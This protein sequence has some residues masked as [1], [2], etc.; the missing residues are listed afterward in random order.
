[1]QH[2]EKKPFQLVP[3]TE[4]VGAGRAFG[5][6]GEL[7]QGHL[8][9]EQTDFLVTLPIDQYSYAL[10]VADGR[11]HDVHI[12]PA[13]KHKAHVLAR[14]ILAQYALPPGGR[15][16]L[17]SELP[18][19][20]GLASSSADL[21]ATAKAI[22]SCFHL[23]IDAVLL[24]TLM[25]QIE[26]SDGVMYPGVVTFHHRQGMLRE[27]FGVLPPLTIVGIDEGGALD[28]IEFNRRRLL[29]T[30]RETEEYQHLLAVL[31]H[32]IRQ[33]D[34]ARIGQV[35]TRSAVMNQAR[36]PKRMLDAC[37]A[38]CKDIDGLGVVAAHSGTCLGILLPGDTGS[39]A[40]IQ[41]AHRALAHLGYVVREYH[42][43]RGF[44]G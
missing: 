4:G 5:T 11:L 44:C 33:H 14:R 2:S 20:K 38:V 28:T 40:Q 31:S 32:A 8:G 18:M 7:L 16:I 29:C 22:G 34:L 17:Q 21:V 35:A 3:W 15:L 12:F 27:F 39:P 41:Q 42:S 30:A 19:G 23:Q 26:P 25:C 6:F 36:N 10:F 1:V 37:I 24:A 43:F 13:E 9:E